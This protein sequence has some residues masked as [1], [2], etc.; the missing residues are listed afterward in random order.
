MEAL[1]DNVLAHVE[2]SLYFLSHLLTE[3][4]LGFENK[5]SQNTSKAKW[6]GSKSFVE[7]KK[8]QQIRNWKTQHH[9]KR[10]EKN[11]IKIHIEM[12]SV[13]SSTV[14]CFVFSLNLQHFLVSQ[15]LVD[16]FNLASTHAHCPQRTLPLFFCQSKD[17]GHTESTCQSKAGS[18]QEVASSTHRKKC[19]YTRRELHK[20]SGQGHRLL[21]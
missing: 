7:W 13:K 8:K 16:T 21:R 11:K 10:M 4:L 18:P 1:N 2:F 20:A 14:C 9:H 12:G 3:S 5:I 17:L 15:S 6:H 19:T